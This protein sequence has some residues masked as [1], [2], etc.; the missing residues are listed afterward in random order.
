MGRIVI[1]LTNR[2]NL[3]CHHCFSGRHGGRDDLPLALFEKILAEARHSGFEQLSFT[4]GDP[5]IHRHFFEILDLSFKAGYRFG[6]NTNGWNF[7][8]IYSG[9]LPYRQRLSVIT[10]SLD[11][12]CAQSHDQLRG[13]GSFRRVM[14]AISICVAEDLPFTINSVVSAHNSHELE[15][16]VRLATRLGSRGLRFGHLLPSPLT[17][18]QNLD[19]S[20]WD[21]KIIEAT[22][23]RLQRISTIRVAIG[24]GSHTTDLFPCAPLN[25]QEINVDC[26]GNLTKCCHLSGQHPDV[27]QRDVIGNLAKLSFSQAYAR[28]VRENEQFHQEKI[29]HLTS[30]SFRDSDFFPCWYCSCYYNKVDWLKQIK[31]HSWA[32]LLWDRPDNQP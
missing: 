11:G 21:R 23:R 16:L 6:F 10:F 32:D 24:P 26:Y 9:L 19:L 29:K 22:I 7:S 12:A 13:N 15:A 1:E 14:Q 25:L 30:Q 3:S 31:G 27:V 2:C 4:G 8:K 18:A 17:T 5:T 28:L 20:P